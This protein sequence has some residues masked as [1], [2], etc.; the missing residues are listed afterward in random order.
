MDVVGKHV[1]I[2]GGSQGIGEAMARAFATAGA[3]VTVVARQADKLAAVAAAVG[4][5]AVVADLLDADRVA[6]LVAEIEGAHGHIDVLVNNAGIE[7]AGAFGAMGVDRIQ[8]TMS[9]NAVVPM[10]LTRQVL[11]AMIERGSGHLVFTSSIAGSSSFP[12][13]AVYCGSKAAVNNFA[14]TVRREVQST[15]IKVTIV[16]PGPVDTAMWGRVEDAGPSAQR[17]VQRMRRLWLLPTASPEAIAAATVKAVQRNRRHVR[18][19]RR[20]LV[21]F[22]LS[23]APRR[24]TEALLAGVRFDPLDRS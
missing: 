1:V 10:Q 18:T 6:A 7:E 17:V 16:A 4:G 20:L 9:L 3:R 23:E 22:W 14:S 13:M 19:P 15:S 12:G 21:T 8:P 2:T 5:N 11:P 24:L